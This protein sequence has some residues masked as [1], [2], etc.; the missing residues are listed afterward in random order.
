[1]DIATVLNSLNAKVRNLSSRNI[2]GNLAMTVITLEVKSANELHYIMGRLA[3][4]P[5][6]SS[7][8]RIGG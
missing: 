1:M 3:A 6:V 2:G 5:A 7:V 4:V 8:T